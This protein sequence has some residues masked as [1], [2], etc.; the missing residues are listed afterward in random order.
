MFNFQ[1]KKFNKSY[2]VSKNCQDTWASAFP[3]VEMQ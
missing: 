2:E 3:W 1:R